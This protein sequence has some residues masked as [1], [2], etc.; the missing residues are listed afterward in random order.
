M[1]PKHTFMLKSILNLDG[2]R[3]LNQEEKKRIAGGSCEI[4]PQRGMP[5]GPV[6]VPCLPDPIPLCCINGVWDYCY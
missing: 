6:C 3:A 2:A 5:C 4:C 1:N